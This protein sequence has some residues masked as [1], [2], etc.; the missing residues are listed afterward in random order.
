VQHRQYVGI[1]LFSIYPV[2][3]KYSLTKYSGNFVKIVT[4][5]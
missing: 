4:E 3:C 2:S 5:V 1:A